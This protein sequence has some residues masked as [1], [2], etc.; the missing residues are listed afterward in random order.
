MKTWMIKVLIIIVICAICILS[1]FIIDD[2]RVT[3]DEKKFRLE[4]ESFNSKTGLLSKQ[5]YV[6]LKIPEK[7]NVVYSSAD[8]VIKLMSDGTG[9]IYLGYPECQ[10]CRSSINDLIKVALESDKTINYYNAYAI[11]DEKTINNE[12][13]TITLQDGSE[14]YYKILDML[15]TEAKNYEEI[16]DDNVKR[17]YF[18]TILFVKNGKIVDGVISDDKLEENSKQLSEKETKELSLLFKKG[19]KKIK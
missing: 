4:Y 5:K 12:G 9:I 19:I 8:D 13:Q 18:P 14:D 10:A 2:T 1:Y 17:L 3:N 16:D 11:R 15:G 7:N 6:D